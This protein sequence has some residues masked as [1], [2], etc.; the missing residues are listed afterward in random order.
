MKNIHASYGNIKAFKGVD[1]NLYNGEI[2][3]LVGEHRAGKS[4]LVKILSSAEK[5]E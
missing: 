2:H 3:A 4:T 1:F 5:E